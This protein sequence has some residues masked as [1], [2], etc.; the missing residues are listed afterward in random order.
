MAH[1][2]PYRAEAIRY[3]DQIDRLRGRLLR[4]A[5]MYGGAARR[6]IATTADELVYSEPD[7][8]FEK[9]KDEVRLAELYK[10]ADL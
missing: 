5:T 8:R 1:A 7:A 2:E 6:V 10:P 9:L 4:V 3:A